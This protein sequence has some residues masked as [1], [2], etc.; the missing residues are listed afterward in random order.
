MFSFEASEHKVPVVH[1]PLWNLEPYQ[2]RSLHLQATEKGFHD[3]KVFKPLS[4]EKQQSKFDTIIGLLETN[5]GNWRTKLLEY[6]AVTEGERDYLLLSSCD[7]N[8]GREDSSQQSQ[9]PSDIKK[10]PCVS[11]QPTTEQLQELE[12]WI[13][14]SFDGN[15]WSV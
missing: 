7:K 5:G 1:T 15:F 3:S 14:R 13:W 9:E 10:Q 8:E 2:T 11:R 12:N 6:L 4:P